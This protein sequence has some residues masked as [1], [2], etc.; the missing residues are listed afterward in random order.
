MVEGN[1][2]RTVWGK[3]ILAAAAAALICACP[4]AADEYRAVHVTGWSSGFL[5]QSEVDKLLGVPGVASSKGDIRNANCNAVFVEVRRRADVCYS[6]A[7][8]EP[9]FSGLS[10]ADF[11]ALQAMI[12]AAHDTTGGKQRIEVHCWIVAFATAGGVVYSRH[13]NPAEPENYWLSLD[14]EGAETADKAFDPGHPKCEDYLV[15]VC[16]DLVT[17]F[18]IDGLHY[19]YI[20]FTGSDQGYNPTSIAR[21]NA[22]YDL[23]GQPAPGDERFKQWRRDQVTALV[24]QVYAR[25]QSVKPWVKQSCSFIGGSP[26]PTASTRE[27]F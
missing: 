1:G 17:N 15:N 23:T 7:M 6:S 16:M 8:E 12:N 13:N 21:Y 27:A 25:I 20:R 11:N 9:Y 26:S 19:D 22:H 3:V 4:G 18:D 24:R 5:R 14:D 2:L 10:P